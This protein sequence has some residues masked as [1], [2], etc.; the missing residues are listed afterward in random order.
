MDEVRNVCPERLVTTADVDRG[1]EARVGD[2]EPT[3]VAGVLPA[4]FDF[5]AVFAPGRRVDVFTPFPLTQET[6]RW[7]NT[8][9]MIGRLKPGATLAAAQA[10]ARVLSD[11]LTKENPNRNNLTLDLSPL[12]NYVS[13][14]FRTAMLFLAG[15]VGLVMLIVCANLSNL[16]LAR[17]ATRE[18]EI[19]IR[20]ALGA[21]RARLIRQLL[22]ESLVLSSAGAALGLILAFGATR[23]LRSLQGISIPLL[24][25]A[26]LD[27]PALGV[28]LLLAVFTGIGFGLVPAL[29]LPLTL[30][31]SLKENTRGTSE[32]RSQGWTRKILIVGEIT[33]ACA[34]VAGA[35]LLIR[36]FTRVLQVELGFRPENAIAIRI[37]PSRSQYNTQPLRNSYFDEALRKVLA[38]PGIEGAG[39]TD[40]L[41]LGR[42]RS[43]GI[44]AKGVTF[45][46]GQSPSPYVRII[47]DGYFRAMGIPIRAGRDFS[48]ADQPDSEKV[49]IM[50]ETLARRIWPGEDPIGKI[51]QTDG[52]ERKVVGIVQDV[53]HLALEQ[54]S[55]PEMYL[56][57]RQTN[58]YPSVD[59]VVR[60]SLSPAGLASS[61]RGALSSVDPA[62]PANEF[63]SLQGLVDRSVSPRRFLVMLLAG[64][65]GFA[66]ILAALGIYGVILYSVTQRRREIGIR[67]AL[68]ATSGNVQRQILTQTLQLTS[69]GIALGVA[70]SWVLG[71]LIRGL[72]Y[73]VTPSD[74]VTY[75]AMLAILGAA[76]G[77]AGYIPARRASRLDP[78]EALR[79]E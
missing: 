60:G 20:A 49:I 10:E 76:A 2:D 56:P 41:P 26:R 32:G 22:T 67:M 64:F 4:S 39:L 7:G 13:G 19:A 16:L 68:G 77:L 14:P 51:V 34:L 28:I 43:W 31:N 9:S 46:R 63:R 33:L 65:A 12:R 44:R 37:D 15:A 54:G 66:L 78:V 42:N 3:T 25:D 75:A 48:P 71:R 18:K 61:V 79:A 45:P 53:R 50:N 5:G 21:G 69:I 47:S 73:D 62:L 59:L 23:V 29:R 17:S 27:L 30:H 72:L 6:N 57:I 70:A 58:D 38:S 11:R 24:A 35:G 40:C 74:P 55:G 52:P 8:M 36:S 1:A